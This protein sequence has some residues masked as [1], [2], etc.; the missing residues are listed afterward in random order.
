V[1][2]GG[3]LLLNYFENLICIDIYPIFVVPNSIFLLYFPLILN[4]SQSAFRRWKV[5]AKYGAS[6][7][8]AHAANVIRKHWCA[9]KKRHFERYGAPVAIQRI[10]RGFWRYSHYVI[11][12]FE[13]TKIQ[14]LVRGHQER[15]WLEHQEKGARLIQNNIRCYLS[16]KKARSIRMRAMLKRAGLMGA[17]GQAASTVIQRWWRGF[18]REKLE[19]A[20]ALVIER[21][22]IMVKDEVDRE[23][24]RIER[25]L[26]TKKK[27][28]KPK[29]EREYVNGASRSADID[30]EGSRRSEN[31]GYHP[32]DSGRDYGGYERGMD[33]TPQNPVDVIKIKESRP[34]R[35]QR[36]AS[37]GGRH[38]SPNPRMGRSF[39]ADPHG[40][41]L[42]ARSVDVDFSGHEMNGSHH[43]RGGYPNND[44]YAYEE[45]TA[46]SGLTIPTA[47]HHRGAS[48]S[49]PNRHR[50]PRSV[51]PS[52]AEHQMHQRQYR[53]PQARY[54]P[55]SNEA[56][57]KD[58]YHGGDRRRV[59]DRNM[60]R[61]GPPS[62]GSYGHGQ[63]QESPHHPHYV[64]KSNSYNGGHPQAPPIY[65]S[66]SNSSRG[67]MRHDQRGRGQRSASPHQGGPRQRSASPHRQHAPIAHQHQHQHHQQHM[68]RSQASRSRIV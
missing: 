26:K 21:F 59:D 37:I 1:Q 32:R 64:E 46:V 52:P 50:H 3:C 31:Y 42:R 47:L 13:I 53:G 56:P 39:D 11:L 36:S 43:S 10:W 60:H 61:H 55:P 15:N 54:G 68:G 8:R 41:P 34:D 27:R 2:R 51:S 40:P 28:R 25:E 17:V 18:F 58:I 6:L 44:A 14:A 30:V 45:D 29:S 12:Q 9:S 24:A 16:R 66:Y 22:F 38:P 7:Q 4:Q 19:K 33:R 35:H 20:A 49:P 65:A 48:P 67:E 5:R 63:Y 23:L 57:I 62:R